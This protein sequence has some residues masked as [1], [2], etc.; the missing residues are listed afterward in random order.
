MTDLIRALAALRRPSLMIRAARHGQA[1]YHRTR[2]L[3]RPIDS[4]T[5]PPPGIAVERLL[6]EE[7]ALEA[8]RLAED[9]TYSLSRH[10]DVLVAL[11]AE[12]QFLQRAPV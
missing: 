6:S 7:E 11:M 3:A 12:A 10:I 8:T 4:A 5:T 1:S 9:P 2:D